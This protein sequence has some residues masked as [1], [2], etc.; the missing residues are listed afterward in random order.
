VTERRAGKVEIVPPIPDRLAASVPAASAPSPQV[1]SLLPA[2]AP[3]SPKPVVVAPSA[4][5]TAPPAGGGVVAQGVAAVAPPTVPAPQGLVVPAPTGTAPVTTAGHAAV[6]APAPAPAGVA[7]SVPGG[8][9]AV[10]PAAGVGRIVL[11]ASADI[12]VT[13]KQKGG[14]ALLNKM[15]HAGDSFA[16]PADKADLTLTTGNAGGTQIEVD[17]AAIP[18]SLGGSGM[19]R[20]DLPLD[21]DALKAGK[22]PAA[23]AKVK[24][25]PKPAVEE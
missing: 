18:V 16:V 24:A 15:M 21:A 22:L 23:P 9:A 3:P 2:T 20:R 1:A 8:A 11:K 14:P 5:V 25:A 19:V 7:A 12:W 10:P 6:G 4:V 17:G 13:I